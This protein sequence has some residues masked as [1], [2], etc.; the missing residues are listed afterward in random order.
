MYSRLITRCHK[1]TT[2]WFVELV[3]G[4]L[5]KHCRWFRATSQGKT[6]RKCSAGCFDQ[7]ILENSRQAGNSFEFETLFMHF[8]QQF[9]L[10]CLW[11]NR[12]A[13]GILSAATFYKSIGKQSG[14]RRWVFFCFKSLSIV[15]FKRKKCEIKRIFVYSKGKFINDV[16]CMQN[17]RCGTNS[18]ARIVV[19]I[20]SFYQWGKPKDF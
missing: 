14:C 17:G 7:G 5:S 2:I 20:G 11:Y 6:R 15:F 4:V 9:L 13:K 3:S 19:V 16:E 10:L 8:F 12:L 1:N 18:L